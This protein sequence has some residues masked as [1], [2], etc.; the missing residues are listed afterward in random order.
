MELEP[1]IKSGAAD[2]TMRPLADKV[3]YATLLPVN[4]YQHTKF[5]LPDSITFGDM[6]GFQNCPSPSAASRRRSR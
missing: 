5:Q 1:K 3:L 6:E 4:A 2:L